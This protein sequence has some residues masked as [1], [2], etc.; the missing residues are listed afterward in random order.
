MYAGRGGRGAAVL[1]VLIVAGSLNAIW[2][3]LYN[4]SDPLV[5]N[6]AWTY[7]LPRILH[8]LFVAYGVI[9]WIWGVADA[10]KVAKKSF[11]I[12]IGGPEL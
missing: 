4:L 6:A 2:L 7:C 3:S 12:G 10:Y 1:A 9:F 8:D 5:A 11:D